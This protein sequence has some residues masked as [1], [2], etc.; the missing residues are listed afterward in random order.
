[1]TVYIVLVSHLSDCSLAA[2]DDII[3]ADVYEDCDDAQS[4]LKAAR[5]NFPQNEGFSV[6]LLEK[7]VSRNTVL[8]AFGD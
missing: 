1:M 4:R 2:P 5:V 3:C 8:E 7:T 6:V